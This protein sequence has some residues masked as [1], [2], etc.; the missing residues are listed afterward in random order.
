VRPVKKSGQPSLRNLKGKLFEQFKTTD[1]KP[2]LK[3]LDHLPSLQIINLLFPL[4]L[5][6]NSQVKWNAV[7]SMGIVTRRIAGEDQE[8]ARNIV[9]RLMWNLNDESGGI[10]WGSAEAMGEILRQTRFLRDEF[11]P[12]L[13]SYLRKDGNFQENEIIQRGVLWGIGRMACKYPDEIDHYV[14]FFL[15][16]LKASD[17]GVRGL[18]AWIAGLLKSKDAVPV[19]QRLLGDESEF[20]TYMK[21]GVVIKTVSQLARKAL[22]K[23]EHGETD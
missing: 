10:G 20:E 9:R 14:Q 22:G 8:S 7:L 2:G 6:T 13:I 23:I 3:D 12:I 4:I 11:L 21:D 19:L 15:P 5:S 1:F 18:S 16:C 17:Q